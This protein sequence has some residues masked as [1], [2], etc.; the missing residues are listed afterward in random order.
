[1]PLAS[2]CDSISYQVKN[3]NLLVFWRSDQPANSELAWGR[4]AGALSES[5]IQNELTNEHWVAINNADPAEGL[6]FRVRSCNSFSGSCS[7]WSDVVQYH[8]TDIA[9][10][11]GTGRRQNDYLDF[12]TVYPNPFNTNLTVVYKLKT[13]CAVRVEIFNTLG[14]VLAVLDDRYR[15]AGEYSCHWTG[16]TADGR[17]LPSGVYFYR[18]TTETET[19]IGKI[20]LMK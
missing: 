14:Q 18:I 6:C 3:G 19:V 9:E 13:A 5:I 11:D 17:P 1:M 12:Y 8:A 16:N 15:P 4:S 20:V 2:L 7:E 10:A